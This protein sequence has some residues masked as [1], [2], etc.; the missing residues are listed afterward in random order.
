MIA[1]AAD[2]AARMPRATAIGVLEL[3][4]VLIVAPLVESSRPWETDA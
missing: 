1:T 4:L 2:A 3:V